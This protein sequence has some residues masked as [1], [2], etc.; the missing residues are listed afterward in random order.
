MEDDDDGRTHLG[1]VGKRIAGAAPRME[2]TG[3]RDRTGTARSG[4]RGHGVVRNARAASAGEAGRQRGCRKWR[5]RQAPAG[6]LI[7]S[8]A[9]IRWCVDGRDVPPWPR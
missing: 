6:G 5:R 8:L 2:G 4:V 1:R 3:S 9:R 7:A